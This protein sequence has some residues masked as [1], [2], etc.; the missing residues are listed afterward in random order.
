MASNAKHRALFFGLYSAI[1]VLLASM[2]TALAQESVFEYPRDANYVVI[3]YT[4][5]QDMILDADPVPLL[6][7]FG[8]G[9]VLVHYPLYMKRAGDYEMRLSDTQLQ[10][11]LNSLEQKGI[12]SFS[13]D[14]ILELKKQSISNKLLAN[15]KILTTRSDDVR[16]KFKVNLSSYLST[17]SGLLQT[18]F[19]KSITWKNLKSDALSH[20]EIAALTDAA[21]AEQELG[22][23]LSH[24]DLVKMK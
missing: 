7:I 24:R 18:G 13:R 6:R 4:Q 19:L 22:Q 3:E 12:L 2:N 23:Y 9:R 11:L 21:A 14:K 10:Q 17:A 1:H 8:D 15:N 5:S 16:S 20:P